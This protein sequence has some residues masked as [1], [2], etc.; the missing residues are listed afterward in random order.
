MAVREPRIHVTW[1]RKLDRLAEYVVAEKWAPGQADAS[2][3]RLIGPH[4][5]NVPSSRSQRPFIP[6]V[7]GRGKPPG[8]GDGRGNTVRCRTWEAERAPLLFPASLFQWRGQEPCGPGAVGTPGRG[9]SAT[10]TL[11][12][13]SV[14]HRDK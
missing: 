8:G 10:T 4:H 5:A 14:A 6:T 1:A 13:L 3:Q 7:Q 11:R 9:V 12:P 2:G